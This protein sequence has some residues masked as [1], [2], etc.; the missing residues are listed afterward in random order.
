MKVIINCDDFGASFGINQA[1]KKGAAYGITTSASIMTNGFAYMNAA[2]LAKTS[3]KKMGLGLHLNL[4]HGKEYKYNFLTYLILL[5]WNNPKLEKQIEKDLDHQFRIAIKDKLNIDHIDGEQHVHI[6]PK[7]FIIVCKLC[8]KYHINAVRIPYE[9]FYINKQNYL[10]ISG[11]MKNFLLRILI[12]QNLKILKQY[13]LKTIDASYGII[14]TSQMTTSVVKSALKNALKNKFNIIEIFL[15]PAIIK[16]PKDKN[17]TGF[18]ASYANLN[19]H[20][21]EANTLQGKDLSNFIKTNKINLT[22]F[23]KF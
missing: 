20:T 2:R 17:L 21:N 4:T 5:A 10:P 14:Y 12:K 22:T 16:H 23:R 8:K 19:A 9:P 6:I 15:H 1:V 11:I 3:L 18:F 13:Q 7:I